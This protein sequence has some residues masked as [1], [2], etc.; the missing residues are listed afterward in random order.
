MVLDFKFLKLLKID[1]TKK[2]NKMKRKSILNQ[3]YKPA[4]CTDLSDIETG[5]KKLRFNVI[6][7]KYDERS[8]II[9]NRLAS[10]QRR[11]KQLKIKNYNVRT[12]FYSLT[13]SQTL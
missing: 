8:P 13:L 10:Y 1:F 2:S 9:V 3:D 5:L 4:D 12:I 11:V 6:T 7:Q